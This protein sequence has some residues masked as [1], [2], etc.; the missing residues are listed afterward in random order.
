MSL[1]KD[2]DAAPSTNS[3]DALLSERIIGGM[4]VKGNSVDHETRCAHYHSPLDII[5]IQFKCCRTY[6]PCFSC[7]QEVADHP[8]EQWSI[9]E[10]TTKA[11]LCG[12]CGYEL[13][14]AEYMACNNTCPS[15]LAS[16]NPNCQKH[17]A[18]YFEGE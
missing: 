4:V 9:S 14:I 11:I 15:C 7:H 16:F 10:R 6:Y 2:E 12:A 18:L 13:T 3:P 17:Y 5:A 1:I 8:A